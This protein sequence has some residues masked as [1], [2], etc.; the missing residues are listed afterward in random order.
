MKKLWIIAMPVFFIMPV[1][2]SAQMEYIIIDNMV[3]KSKSRSSVKFSHG[4]HMA[5]EGAACNDCH[6]R[7]ENGKNVLDPVELNSDNRTIYCSYCHTDASK[8]RN[9][10]HRLCIGCHES[11]VKKNKAPGPRLCGECHK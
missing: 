4:N 7:F 3:F 8:L 9:S 10:Y 2:L 5:I 6:H 11:M 1:F